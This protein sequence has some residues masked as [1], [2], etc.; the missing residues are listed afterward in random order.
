M[1]PVVTMGAVSDRVMGIVSAGASGWQ[2]AAAFSNISRTFSLPLLYPATRP[3]FSSQVATRRPKA[4]LNTPWPISWTTARKR[5]LCLMEPVVPR[6]ISLNMPS[7]H[8]HQLLRYVEQTDAL[9]EPGMGGARKDEF[10][11]SESA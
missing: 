3:A 6:E 5:Y 4:W 7:D 11:E 8:V 1:K 2:S 9:G 10:G